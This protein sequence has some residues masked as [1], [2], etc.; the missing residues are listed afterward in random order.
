[1]KRIMTSFVVAFSMIFVL[2]GNMGMVYANN[3]IEAPKLISIKTNHQGETLS[4]GD[5]L[6]I[7]AEVQDES[8]LGF[9]HIVF[10]NKSTNLN[11]SILLNKE[12]K[13]RMVNFTAG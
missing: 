12:E 13:K 10:K 6:E 1:M 8:E 3:D 5:E 2:F 7:T 11:K 4:P 9:C